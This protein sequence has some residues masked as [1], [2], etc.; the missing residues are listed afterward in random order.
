[1]RRKLVICLLLAALTL[2]AFWPVGRLGFSIYDDE[3]YVVHN[4]HVA[5][6]LTPGAIGWAFTSMD[7]DGWVPMTWLSH[8]LDCQ[9]FGLKAGAHHWMNLGIHV[10]NVLLL[11]LVLAEMF[12]KAEGRRQSAEGGHWQNGNIQHSTFN[13]QHRMKESDPSPLIPLPSEGR[14]KEDAGMGTV[15]CC[16]LAAAVFA[17]HPLRVESVAW[18]TERK[19]VLS[20]LFFM[21][22]LLCYAKA[23][24]SGEWRVTNRNRTGQAEASLHVSRFTLHLTTGWRWCFLR[25]G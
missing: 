4:P 23:V 8:M 6:G 5:A 15:W 10:A 25:W 12:K 19:D 9:W 11:F 21:L 3:D 16:A 22:T 1:M 14:G 17:V 7:T 20:G 13:I 18:V 2:A 24:T